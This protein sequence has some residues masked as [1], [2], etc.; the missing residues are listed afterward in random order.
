MEQQERRPERE[1]DGA[2]TATAVGVVV[3][4]GAAAAAALEAEAGGRVVAAAADV[5]HVVEEEAE[6]EVGDPIGEEV[7]GPDD[8]TGYRR[9]G[10]LAHGAYKDEE[11]LEDQAQ[12]HGRP[13]L[14]VAVLLR[15]RRVETHRQRP[16]CLPEACMSCVH[17]QSLIG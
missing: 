1:D 4:G 9:R 16:I 11:H 2:A 7:A 14:P 6:G 10:A 17:I 3:A 13:D 12:Q 15:H 5:A 8:E